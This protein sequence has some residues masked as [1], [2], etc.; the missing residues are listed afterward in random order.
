M[1][2]RPDERRQNEA[3]ARSHMVRSWTTIAVLLGC[4]MP[5][6]ATW[7]VDTRL[8]V[9]PEGAS[10]SA[11]AG[12]SCDAYVPTF[13][14]AFEEAALLPNVGDERPHVAVCLLPHPDLPDEPHEESIAIE[15]PSGNLG[16]PLELA[17]WD[18]MLCPDLTS[19][20]DQ[21][22]LS[23]ETSGLVIVQGLSSDLRVEGVCGESRPGVSLS[24]GGAVILGV[25]LDG[26]SGYGI[27]NGVSAS[28]VELNVTPSSLVNGTGP[29]LHSSGPATLI[30]VLVAGYRLDDTNGGHAVIWGEANSEVFIRS[31][32]VLGTLVEGGTEARALLQGPRVAI[33]NSTIVANGLSG[34]PLARL[35]FTPQVYESAGVGFDSAVVWGIWNSV[36][37]RNRVLA[38]VADFTVPEQSPVAWPGPT[39]P[40]CGGRALADA[41]VDLASPFE[42][43]EGGTGPLV[44][45]DPTLGAVSNGESLFLRSFFVENEL[46]DA[47]LVAFE[48]GG[49]SLW[50]QFL[51]NT[52]AANDARRLL[53]WTDATPGGG[54]VALRNLQGDATDQSL[55]EIPN[56]LSTVT[57]SLNVG[58]PGTTWIEPLPNQGWLVGPEIEA[59]AEFREAYFV[60]SLADCDRFQLLCPG[61]SASDCDAWAEGSQRLVCGLDAAAAFVPSEAFLDSV[62]IAWPWQTTFFSP[63]AEGSAIAGA[64]G[65]RCTSLR[66][67]AD[68]APE[69]GGVVLGDMDLHPDA[70]DCDN[71]DPDLFPRV[72]EHDGISSEYCDAPEGSCY[73]CPEGSEPPPQDD[74]DSST[75]DDDD[76]SAKVPDDDDDGNFEF[77][78]GCDASGCGF[79]WSCDEGVLAALPLLPLLSLRRNRRPRSA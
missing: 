24:G 72:P 79:A 16:A 25:Q 46:G 48:G 10:E 21:P 35:G 6:S 71:E 40:H 61:V 54:V 22:L 45:L 7:A 47:P 37:S 41:W 36:I 78:P 29:A 31:S 74:D 34:A 63:V 30:E 56:Y 11:C 17:L 50:I 23:V 69:P 27:R 75:S 14:H 55:M 52:F 8:C 44:V 76:D 33:D 5:A 70:V 12:G 77:E 42:E 64:T 53:E 39:T 62:D 58:P 66:G 65:W 15:D 67:T 13:S 19:S 73:V 18:R 20:A 4:F 51:H 38:S 28:P 59:I 60:R 3:E 9:S 2:G 32:V 1:T 26:A 68:T 49:T 43:L 57:S